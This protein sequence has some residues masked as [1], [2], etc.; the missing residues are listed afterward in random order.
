MRIA[1]FSDSINIPPK[2]GIN[3]HTYGLL[4]E[5]ANRPDC[6]PVLIVCD[7]GWLSHDL[8]NE[9]PFETIL[10]PEEYFYN[11]SYISRLL[12]SQRFDIAQSYMTYF[13][14]EVL[15]PAA[16]TAEVPMVAEFHDLEESVVP[17]YFCKD[18]LTEAISTHTQFQLR[19]AEYASLVRMISSYDLGIIQQHWDDYRH[20]KYFWMPV[21]QSLTSVSSVTNPT[22]IL[23]IGNMSYAPNAEGGEIIRDQLA[24]K[25]SGRGITFIGRGSQRFSTTGIN[26]LGPVD[27][28]SPYLVSTA[29]GLSPIVSGSGMKIKN[30]TYLS[31]GIPCISTTFGANSFPPSEA[32]ILEDDISKWPAIIEKI[33]GDHGYRQRLSRIA[34]EYFRN[35]FDIRSNTDDLLRRY[36]AA[37]EQ[38][39][40]IRRTLRGPALDSV[41]TLDLRHVYWLRELREV[42]NAR[43][44]EPLHII[45]HYSHAAKLEGVLQ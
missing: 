12:K 34:R 18:E 9:Q 13:S 36:R 31:N 39:P 2:E 27:D 30:L 44:V 38:Y 29:V 19:A 8:L 6:D 41:C 26:A 42:G 5:L 40:I 24:G 20:D 15:G 32:I 45:P 16:Y 1:V 37:I 10:V 7:R 23:Y 4:I 28:I 33:I 25:L 3:V 43:V 21:S 35:H 11:V 17:L 22:G 14:A